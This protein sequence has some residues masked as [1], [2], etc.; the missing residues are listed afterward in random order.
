[1]ADYEVV[2]WEDFPNLRTPL[3]ATNLRH[4][5][6]Q[7]KLNA[8]DIKELK[9]KNTTFLLGT[10]NKGQTVANFTS[11]AFTDNSVVTIYTKPY[12]Y[13]PKSIEEVDSTTIKTIWNTQSIDL[14]LVVKIEN[15]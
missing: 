2:G 14:K 9:T 6:N 8:D 10:L 5:D 11:E 7:I 15:F 13:S 1:M 4:M 12:G 3:T